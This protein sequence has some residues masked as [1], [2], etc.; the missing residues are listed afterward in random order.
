V[1]DLTRNTGWV[2]VGIDHD[3][4][5]FAVETLRRWWFARGRHDY[6]DTHALLVT[7]DAGGSNRYYQAIH[8]PAA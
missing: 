4:A 7:A 2:S 6:P 3:T 1:C 8:Q 5:A